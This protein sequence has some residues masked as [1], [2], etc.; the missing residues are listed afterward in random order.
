MFA[1]LQEK[2]PLT[3]RLDWLFVV[4][5]RGMQQKT[6]D[7]V[8]R[9]QLRKAN[10]W[11]TRIDEQ[12]VS[13]AEQIDRVA[14][15]AF[16]VVDFDGPTPFDHSHELPDK[17]QSYGSGCLLHKSGIWGDITEGWVLRRSGLYWLPP[18]QE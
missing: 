18:S 16:A 5:H 15:F 6:F 3:D 7:F 4:I 10:P 1:I 14:P 11:L 2:A 9:D 13:L 12:Y 8:Y 17:I